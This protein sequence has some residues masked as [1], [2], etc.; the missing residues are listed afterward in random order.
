MAQSRG[1]ACTARREIFAPSPTYDASGIPFHK[2]GEAAITGK[3]YADK[4]DPNILHD[5]ITTRDHALKRPWTVTRSYRRAA[6]AQPEWLEVA[7]KQDNSRVLIGDQ[8]YRVSSD[9]L[10]MPAVRGQKRPDLKY[11]K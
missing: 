11:F 5:E 7:C 1:R 4:A 6:E 10:L 2:D 3:V 8:Y 9:G